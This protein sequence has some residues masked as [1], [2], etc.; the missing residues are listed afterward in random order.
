MRSMNRSLFISAL[1]LPMLITACDPK[2]AEARANT[3]AEVSTVQLK[4]NNCEHGV[5][6]ALAERNMGVVSEADK[7]DAVL[8][9]NVKTNGRNLDEVPE[10]GGF[11]NKASYSATL[12]GVDDEVIFST[13][14]EEGSITFDEMCEDIGDEIAERIQDRKHA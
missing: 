6:E 1:T 10:F 11:G 3:V 2:G 5:Q 8:E 7:A 4:A 12:Y 14:G 13:A 9:I